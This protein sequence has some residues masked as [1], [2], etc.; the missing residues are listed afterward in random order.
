MDQGTLKYLPTKNTGKKFLL[1]V[2]YK[3]FHLHFH[4]FQVS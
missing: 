3:H 4:Y 2:I 1:T